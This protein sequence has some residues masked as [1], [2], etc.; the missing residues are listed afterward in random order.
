MSASLNVDCGSTKYTEILITATISLFV[1]PGLIVIVF[2]FFVIGPAVPYIEART[3]RSGVSP[4][5]DFI[6]AKWKPRKW[7]FA[8]IDMV[9]KDGVKRYFPLINFICQ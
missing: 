4:L 7:R 1:V 6:I 5:V 2:Y 8:F 3:K 9:L